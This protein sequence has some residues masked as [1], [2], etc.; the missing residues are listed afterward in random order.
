MTVS[1]YYTNGPTKHNKQASCSDCEWFML[2]VVTLLF[3]CIREESAE[4]VKEYFKHKKLKPIERVRLHGYK[5]SVSYIF[6]MVTYYCRFLTLPAIV[7]VN[8]YMKPIYVSGNC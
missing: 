1:I 6:V 3:L 8:S 5:E 7:S 2:A 4:I